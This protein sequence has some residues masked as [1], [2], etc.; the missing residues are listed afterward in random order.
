MVQVVSAMNVSSVEPAIVS[1]IGGSEVQ[2]GGS[3]FEMTGVYCGVG[4]ATWSSSMAS[5]LSSTQARCVLPARGD[6]MRV[7]E[8]SVGGGE[9]SHSGVQVEYMVW[10]KGAANQRGKGVLLRM[11]TKRDVK[12]SINQRKPS[13]MTAMVR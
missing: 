9:M 2:I 10:R 13:K 4:G 5:V 8:V 12:L 11:A 6:G 3:G 7:V 1:V